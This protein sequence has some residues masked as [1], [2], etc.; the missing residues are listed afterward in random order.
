MATLLTNYKKLRDF[1]GM[2][3]L[4][5]DLLGLLLEPLCFPEPLL[6]A[7]WSSLSWAE[8]QRATRW[9]PSFTSSFALRPSSTDFDR[10]RT[11]EL[12]LVCKAFFNALRKRPRVRRAFLAPAPINLTLDGSVYD[13]DLWPYFAARVASKLTDNVKGFVDVMEHSM[14]VDATFDLD[15]RD[16]TVR[17]FCGDSV[18]LEN[19][20]GAVLFFNGADSHP[21]SLLKGMM[22]YIIKVKG[23][24]TVRNMVIVTSNAFN[25]LE[26]ARECA[27]LWNLPVYEIKCSQRFSRPPLQQELNIYEAVRDVCRQ[28]LRMRAMHP[29]QKKKCLLM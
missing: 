4:P 7:N 19:F 12:C 26:H 27:A 14:P 9:A 15:G 17:M 5:K 29:E 24:T 18:R 13:G 28:V 3:V 25:E 23:W 16:V 11:L 8:K 2:E 1:F 10:E 21:R 22:D 20:D 6:V